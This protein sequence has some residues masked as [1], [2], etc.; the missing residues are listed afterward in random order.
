MLTFVMIKPAGFLKEFFDAIVAMLKNQGMV[1]R[2]THRHVTKE[3]AEAHYA[4]HRG[5]ESFSKMTGYLAGKVV[6]AL[7]L[8]GPDVI[9]GVRRIVGAT[10]PGQAAPG[11][12]RHLAAKRFPDEATV[13]KLRAEGQYADNL[14]HASD[15]PEAAEM[16]IK[17]WFPDL[18]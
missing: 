17:L 16:E 3:L 14:V 7:V 15:S 5:K 10:W 13:E 9:E 12:I 8:E 6:L 1:I 11:T 2:A 18:A 4:V